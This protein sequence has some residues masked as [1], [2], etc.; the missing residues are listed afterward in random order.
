MP[1]LVV[2]W[3]LPSW[4]EVAAF[5]APCKQTDIWSSSPGQAGLPTGM[6][7]DAGGACCPHSHSCQPHRRGSASLLPI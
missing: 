7:S 6:R 3:E 5:P 2:T 4:A 1:V